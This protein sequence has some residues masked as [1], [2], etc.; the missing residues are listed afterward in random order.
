M[1]I[2]VND[3]TITGIYEFFI[4]ANLKL[5]PEIKVYSNKVTIT[6]ECGNEVVTASPSRLVLPVYWINNGTK[7]INFSAGLLGYFSS[8]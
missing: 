1:E 7:T 2:I 5:F 3:Y 8:S 6:V 4:Y